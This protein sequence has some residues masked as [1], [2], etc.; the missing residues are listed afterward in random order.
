MG[1]RCVADFDGM[2]VLIDKI[3][4]LEHFRLAS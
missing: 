4:S 2:I 3:V 1:F